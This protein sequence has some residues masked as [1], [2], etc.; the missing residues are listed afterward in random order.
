MNRKKNR[1][2]L[3]EFDGADHSFFNFNVSK[4]RYDLSMAAADRF[5]SDLGYFE[6]EPDFD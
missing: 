5:L 6:F 4:T 1:C 3:V 2:D